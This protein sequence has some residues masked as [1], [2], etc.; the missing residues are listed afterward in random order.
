LI[1]DGLDQTQQLE[2]RHSPEKDVMWLGIGTRVCKQ[3]RVG[4]DCYDSFCVLRRSSAVPQDFSGSNPSG[5][6]TKKEK[7][8]LAKNKKK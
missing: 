3:T 7:G 1:N 8:K 5:F 4:C 2:R 6:S